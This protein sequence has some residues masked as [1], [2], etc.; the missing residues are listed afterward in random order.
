MDAGFSPRETVPAMPE[1]SVVMLK[2]MAMFLVMAVGW[3][4]YRRAYIND[5]TVRFLSRLVVDLVFPCMV[6]AQ[7]LRSVDADVLS[8]GWFVPLLG[9]G[10]LLI[11]GIAGL[12]VVPWF[13][14]RAR[15]PTA[16]FLSGLPNWIFLPLPIV[17]ALYGDAGVRDVLLINIGAQLVMWSVGVWVLRGAASK[18][19]SLKSLFTNPGLLATAIGI[20]LALLW[21]EARA[22][23]AAGGAA[24]PLWKFLAAAVIQAMNILGDL[25]IPLS[26]L[27]TGAQ[28][29]ALPA[30]GTR[31]PVMELTAVVFARLGA[32]PFLTV[33]V[34]WLLSGLGFHIPEDTRLI[35]YLISAM[36]VAISASIMSERFGGNNLL[37]ARAIFWSTVLSMATVPVFFR[38][39][40]IWGV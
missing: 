29:A 10:I 30:A 9:G 31:P 4:A 34:F 37:S 33:A 12:I 17:E 15:L 39:V 18:T 13:S 28:L 27:I 7:M 36:P 16:V 5:T 20:V 1:F 38:L 25:T 24:L 14:T 21:P 6:L 8:W 22:L 35:C 11:A 32:G 40:Q 3:V 26:L 23:D 19:M 2:I